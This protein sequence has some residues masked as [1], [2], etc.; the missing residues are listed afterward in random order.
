MHEKSP[1]LQ[2]LTILGLHPGLLLGVTFLSAG[3]RVR[4]VRNEFAS[5]LLMLEL[6]SKGARSSRPARC[7]RCFARPDQT[8]QIEKPQFRCGRTLGDQHLALRLSH[9]DAVLRGVDTLLARFGFSLALGLFVGLI[10]ANFVVIIG[11]GEIERS[12]LE[13]ERWFVGHAGWTS[14]RALRERLELS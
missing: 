6:R 8:L 14:C 4:E 11:Y 1:N 10:A 7:L 9:H 12:P 3:Y 2:R 5:S 13:T